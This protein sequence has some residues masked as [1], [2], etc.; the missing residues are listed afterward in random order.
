M[1][2]AIVIL[3]LCLGFALI[4]N[5][6][7]RPLMGILSILTKAFTL[8]RDYGKSDKKYNYWVLGTNIK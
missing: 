3:C 4:E 7:N 5:D 8:E 2:P 6:A 1:I